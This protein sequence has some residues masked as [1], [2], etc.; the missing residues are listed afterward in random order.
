MQWLPVLTLCG[1]AASARCE[2]FGVWAGLDRT[3]V[4]G[5]VGR[6]TTRPVQ[7]EIDDDGETAA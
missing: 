5:K 7:I 1:E 3:R 4:P 6:P 2:Q